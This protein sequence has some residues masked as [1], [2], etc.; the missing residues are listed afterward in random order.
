MISDALIGIPALLRRPRFKS[1]SHSGKP[2]QVGWSGQSVSTDLLESAPEWIPGQRDGAGIPNN[3]S[4]FIMAVPPAANFASGSHVSDKPVP[5]SRAG[6]P[7]I[8]IGPIWSNRPDSV[9]DWSPLRYPQLLG[10]RGNRH[11]VVRVYVRIVRTP[12]C[13]SECA[14]CPHR[15]VDNFS[16]SVDKRPGVWTTRC[17]YRGRIGAYRWGS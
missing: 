10:R 15:I 17:T 13:G 9:R 11:F 2:T 7:F 5:I 12:G 8:A 16:K 4:I 6:E 1:G 14:L 3:K